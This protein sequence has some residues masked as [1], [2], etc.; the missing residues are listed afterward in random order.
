MNDDGKRVR[1]AAEEI[2]GIVV[3]S[4]D[5]FAG[6]DALYR[7]PSLSEVIA[8]EV[9]IIQEYD[10]TFLERNG[11]YF[12]NDPEGVFFDLYCDLYGKEGIGDRMHRVYW[13]AKVWTRQ[14]RYM[15]VPEIKDQEQLDYAISNL[16][17]IFE[18]VHTS[19]DFCTYTAPLSQ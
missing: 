4:D 11:I 5:F 8:E 18:G 19:S 14:I 1:R 9:P 13:S 12:P 10:P 3:D 7:R 6:I 16:K 17:K 2:G 15:L